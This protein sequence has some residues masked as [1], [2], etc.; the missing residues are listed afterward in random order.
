M[1]TLS[2]IALTTI[3]AF[4]LGTSAHAI[5]SGSYQCKMDDHRIKV[6]EL[7]K[8]GKLIEHIDDTYQNE[9]TIWKRNGKWKNHKKR[10][11]QIIINVG[12]ESDPS[13]STTGNLWQS[14]CNIRNY[15]FVENLTNRKHN[16]KKIR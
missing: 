10:R 8:N 2:K 4:A 14:K 7:R 16:C 3:A 9:S 11:A 5:Q 13:Y 1:K 15:I 6:F 12:S